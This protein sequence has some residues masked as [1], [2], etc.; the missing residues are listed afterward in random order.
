MMQVWFVDDL[1]NTK[2]TKKN[3]SMEKANQT[4]WPGVQ[5]ENPAWKK[6]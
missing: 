3:R 4:G 1:L 5:S 2:M 6:T